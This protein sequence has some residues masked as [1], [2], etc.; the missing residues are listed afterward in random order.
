MI[1]SAAGGPTAVA[2]SVRALLLLLLCVCVHAEAGLIAKPHRK[3]PGFPMDLNYTPNGTQI[4]ITNSGR[5]FNRPLYGEANGLV[6]FGGDRPIVKSGCSGM[7]QGTL[8]VALRRGNASGGWAHLDMSATT[9]AGY[10]PGISSWRYRSPLLPDVELNMTVAPTDGGKGLAV[11]LAIASGDVQAGDELLWMYA[12]VTAGYNPSTSDPSVTT[13]APGSNVT[14]IGPRTDQLLDDR[15]NVKLMQIGF[16]PTDAAG[17]IVRV[18]GNQFRISQRGKG[19]LQTVFGKASSTTQ[20]SVRVVR[21]DPQTAGWQN[22]SA[23]LP[24][25][26]LGP[27]PPSPPSPPSPPPPPRNADLPTNG[28]VLQLEVS[29]LLAHGMKNGEAIAH[30]HANGLVS[31]SSPAATVTFSQP[32]HE[33]QPTFFLSNSSD[34]TPPEA[35]VRFGGSTSLSAELSLPAEKTIVAVTRP[36]SGAGRCCNALVCTYQQHG[37]PTTPARMGN[38]TNGV[39]VK[40]AG[41][42]VNLVVD[43]DGED[44]HGYIDLNARSVILSVR[45]NETHAVGRVSGCDEVVLPKGVGQPSDTIVLGSRASDPVHLS[46]RFFDGLVADVIVYNRSLFEAE[47]MATE[48]HL[49]YKYAHRLPH[50]TST[51]PCMAPQNTRVAEAAGGVIDLTKERDEIFLS[52]EPEPAPERQRETVQETFAAAAARIDR[53]QK[54]VVVETPDAFMN[55]GIPCA[56]AAIDG[57]WRDQ[58]PVYV[59]GE[60]RSQT[61]LNVCHESLAS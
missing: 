28:L 30:W 19:G 54:R 42:A 14:S 13:N 44:N 37:S 9:V 35:W 59:H 5:H 12:G 27:P 15:G 25:A 34:V 53:L 50:E 21:F 51:K 18:D 10:R 55:A 43:Y 11:R 45:Y 36:G 6:V 57:L 47:L 48:E 20:G 58:P 3:R 8:M 1:A 31:S 23:L 26:A 7:F 32:N 52:F 41:T 16:N 39:A 29:S 4:E 17:N 56:G 46:G 60:H 38:S 33:Q 22:V 24:S 40:K 49:A 61:F 2:T